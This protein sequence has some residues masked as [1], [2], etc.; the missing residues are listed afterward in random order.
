LDRLK[1]DNETWDEFLH[2]VTSSEEPIEAD[3]WTDEKANRTKD[4]IREVRDDWR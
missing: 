4:G 3:A 1:R 2:R